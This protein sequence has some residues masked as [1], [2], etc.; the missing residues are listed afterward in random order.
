MIIITILFS[1]FFYS[2]AKL[3]VSQVLKLFVL[4]AD[5]HIQRQVT[6]VSILNSNVTVVIG[7]D[8]GIEC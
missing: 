6:S 5:T 7:V 2:C 8:L 3:S 1:L 4:H